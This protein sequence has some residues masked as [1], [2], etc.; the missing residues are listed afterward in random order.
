MKCMHNLHN[1]HNFHMFTIKFANQE[2]SV[3]TRS[4]SVWTAR[5]LTAALVFIDTC[6]MLR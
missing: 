2:E 3:A 6:D 4:L 1:L 5:T